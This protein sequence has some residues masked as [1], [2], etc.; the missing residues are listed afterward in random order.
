MPEVYMNASRIVQDKITLP[1]EKSKLFPVYY[2]AGYIYDL[3]EATAKAWCRT[4]IAIPIV[5]NTI[6]L[7]NGKTVTLTPTK[8]AQ[9]L[10]EPRK[11]LH[12]Q[13]GKR[14]RPTLEADA[15]EPKPKA[16]STKRKSTRK[17]KT[18]RKAAKKAGK[19]SKKKK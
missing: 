14:T 4:F 15:P 10:R 11:P 7:R 17:K 2:D 13:V 5:G 9:L 8:R 1:D 6:A 16:K 19:R 3:P 18:T 12:P